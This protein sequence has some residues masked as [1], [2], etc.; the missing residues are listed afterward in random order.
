MK[1]ENT[2]RG[3]GII[4]FIDANGQ[5]CSIQQ[6]SAI[7]DIPDAL[8]NPGSSFLWI[9][10][11]GAR[12]HASKD[13]VREIVACLQSWIETGSLGTDD[14]GT[15]PFS[16]KTC[17]YHGDIEDFL[18]TDES[19]YSCPLCSSCNCSRVAK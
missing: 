19:N 4:R 11:D 10:V 8:S 6:S 17:N 9:G 12:I 1:V 5:N 16:C 2:E 15:T 3:F 7:G 13:Q 14:E 18:S